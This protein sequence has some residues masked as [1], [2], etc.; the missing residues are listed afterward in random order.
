MEQ[1]GDRPRREDREPKAEPND[2]RGDRRNPRRLNVHDAP[3]VLTDAISQGWLKELL[4][5]AGTGGVK[6]EGL[7]ASARA[8]IQGLRGS[9]RP[10]CR[11]PRVIGSAGSGQ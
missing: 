7:R 9:D 4:A 5:A 8:V 6:R 3:V 2:D 1:A 10:M 11:G